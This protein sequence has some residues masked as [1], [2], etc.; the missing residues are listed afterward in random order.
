MV[1]VPMVI[2]NSKQLREQSCKRTLA[3]FDAHTATT[4][5]Q[6]VYADCVHLLYPKEIAQQ[7]TNEGIFLL[8]LFIIFCTCIA[9]IT[10][11]ALYPKEDK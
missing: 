8:F 11:A 1:A 10:R 3:D 6:I 7:E 4:Q 9:G 2:S 5:E